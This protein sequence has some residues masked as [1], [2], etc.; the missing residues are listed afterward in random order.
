[1][2]FS[3]EEIQRIYQTALLQAWLARQ[4]KRAA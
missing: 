1:M 3:P 4:E 2:T